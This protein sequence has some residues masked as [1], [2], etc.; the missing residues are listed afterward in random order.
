L[1]TLN[2]LINVDTLEDEVFQTLDR[3]GWIKEENY[4]GNGLQLLVLS[5]EDA[6]LLEWF[7]ELANFFIEEY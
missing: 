1:K 6:K 4:E 7:A 2:Y 5:N 3:L